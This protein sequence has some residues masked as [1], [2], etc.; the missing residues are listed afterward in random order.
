MDFELICK[1]A[2]MLARSVIEE[3]G[4]S[5]L[6]EV[7]DAHVV[8]ISTEADMAV[9]DA[10]MRFFREKKI[11]A[12]LFSEESG[13]LVLSDD[14]KYTITFDDIDGTDNY[15]RGRGIL[16]YCTVITIFDSIELKFENAIAAGIIEHNSGRIWLASRGN[17]CCLDGA[18]VTTSGRTSLDRRALVIIDHYMGADN[19]RSLE[20]IY[21]S[22][23]VK[24]FGSAAFHLAGVSSGLFD[25]YI[26]PC[27]KAH[28]LGAGYL[29]IKE[30]GGYL[31]DWNGKPLDKLQY[32]FNA[33]YQIA[34]A[35]TEKL[36]RQLLSK[37]Q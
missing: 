34:A 20:A 18:K 10:L 30:A 23:W 12:V 28:E 11:P 33:K 16:P 29:L 2:L 4:S 35:A 14:P 15:H 36:G 22:S 1:E 13:R 24:D 7:H 21:P 9:S 32:D 37:L 25:A 19:I 8:D 26:S 5:G 27:Q 31:A 6:K 17:G 3:A